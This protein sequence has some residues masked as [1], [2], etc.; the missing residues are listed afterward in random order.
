MGTLVHRMQ[1][2]SEIH[3]VTLGPKSIQEREKTTFF[4]FFPLMAYEGIDE[5]RMSELLHENQNSTLSIG[6]TIVSGLLISM[7]SGWW[8]AFKESQVI[9]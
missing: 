2:C 8:I 5:V 3:R 4:L 1:H 9:V 6:W 7:W